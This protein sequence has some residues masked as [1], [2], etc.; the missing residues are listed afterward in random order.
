MSREPEKRPHIIVIMVDDM[1]YS[2]PGCFG[3]EMATPA[4][5]RLAR[6]GVRLTHFYN[7]RMCV[8][9]RASFR[10]GFATV[11]TGPG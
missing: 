11:D 8:V 6:E 5:D 3:S 2:D 1:G 7:C 4:L 10:N 9:S